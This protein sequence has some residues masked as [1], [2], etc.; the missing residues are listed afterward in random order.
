MTESKLD[1]KVRPITIQTCAP[2]AT[3]VFLAGTFNNWNP[4]SHAMEDSGDGLWIAK[5]FLPP[6]SYEYKFIVDGV[7][8]CRPAG[9][10]SCADDPE[11]LPNP[12]DSFNL[13]LEVT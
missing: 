13:R 4:A 9:D 10:E 8:C 1:E 6:G 3:A 5:L 7:W 11:C 12:F 2:G